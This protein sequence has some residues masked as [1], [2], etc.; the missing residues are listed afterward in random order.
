M[1][2]TVLT[3]GLLLVSL[4]LYS[5]GYQV[6]ASAAPGVSGPKPLA[7]VPRSRPARKKISRQAA[8]ERPTAIV[9][10]GLREEIRKAAGLCAEKLPVL[11]LAGGLALVNGIVLA[12]WAS[13]RTGTPTCELY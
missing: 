12:V 13:R 4:W 1:R 5:L 7:A 6:M 9:P 10:G 3:A 8:G 2:S 11:P